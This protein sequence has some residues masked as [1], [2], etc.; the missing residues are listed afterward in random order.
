MS[1]STPH[2]QYNQY[3]YTWSCLR[4]AYSG[5]GAVKSAI[6]MH[7]PH[8]GV[9]VAGTRYL[10]RPAGMKVVQGEDQYAAYR[11]RAIFFGATERV[12]H[13]LTGTIFRREYDLAAPTSLTPHLEDI[14][15]TGVPLRAFSE[16]MVRETLLMGRA[17]ILVDFPALDPDETG[18]FLPAFET[19][20]YWVGYRAEEML[21]WR[22]TKRQGD[23]VLSL[24]VLKE[25]VEEPQGVWPSDDFFLITEQ[26]QY[27]VL[28]L[29]EQGLYEV[30]VWREVREGP[31]RDRVTIV[32]GP[33]RIPLR[34][35]EPLDFIPFVF[36]A[37][38]SLEPA[39]E[40]SLLEAL[41]EVN[42]QYYRHSADYEHGL[43]LTALPTPYICASM[44]DPQ[45]ELLIGS[46]IAWVIKDSTAKVGMLEFNGQGL[47][48]H[49]RAL[50]NDVKN[51]AALG[52][53]LL[54]G[55]P[56]VPET[57]TSVITRMQGAE[58]P[59]QSLVFTVSQGL[60]QCLQMHAWW[61]GTTEDPADTAIHMHLNK[62]LVA[63]SMD[64]A[65]LKALMEAYLNG[66]MTFETWF[67]N[68]QKGE[69]TRPQ[70]TAEEEKDLI[71]LQQAQRPLA[72]LLPPGRAL[73]GQQGSASPLPPSTTNG[74]AA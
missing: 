46:A 74:V 63:N 23:T 73:G 72:Q 38:F 31:S 15:Q 64:P 44:L 39:I 24:V 68:L 54:E 49:E 16:Q 6:D 36:L 71:E 11:D 8:R 48:S 53:R 13:G 59:M 52:A 61:A 10:P 66:T 55:S 58:S 37:P 47:Q 1:V 22:T 51:M 4:D 32:P 35:G 12:V 57:A 3:W 65:M 21:N 5:S 25:C 40:K 62:D 30:S 27:R 60:T 7:H 19:R 45:T 18:A 26:I 20:P 70:V 28:R 9:R 29:N 41:V 50:D 34:N 17:G 14:T 69:I 2:P 67:H 42:F 56:L 43:H 33:A